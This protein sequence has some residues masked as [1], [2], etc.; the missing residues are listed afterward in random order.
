MTPTGEY[1]N[2]EELLIREG[3]TLN[4]WEEEGDWVLVGRLGQEGEGRGVGFVPA[5]YIEVS[6]AQG[7][8]GL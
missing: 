6:T 8:V 2:E 5:S 1:E 4:L 7:A 3:E